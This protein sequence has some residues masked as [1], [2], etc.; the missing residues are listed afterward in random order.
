MKIAYLVAS[1][2]RR[3]GGPFVSVRRTAQ[4]LH[5]L[6]VEIKVF[7]L[8]DADTVADLPQWAPL[9]PHTFQAWVP[10]SFGFSPALSREL[11]RFGP[12]VVHVHGMWSFLTLAGRRCAS[13]NGAALVISPRGMFEP[14]AWQHRAWKKRPVWWLWERSCLRAARVIHATSLMELKGLRALGQ[15]NDIAVLPNGVDLPPLQPHDQV[16]FVRTA[17]FLSRIHP[18]KGLLNL[19]AAWALVRPAGWKCVVAGWDQDGHAKEVKRA[20]K[21]CGLEKDFEFPGPA[22]DEAKMNLLQSASLFVLPTFSEN[23]GIAVAE[24]LAGALPVITTKGAPWEELKTH[25]CGWWVD[26]GA[27]PLAA[28]FREAIALSDEQR[29][30][31]GQRG[32][33]LVAQK[34]AWPTI[35]LQMKSVYEWLLRGGEPPQCVLRPEIAAV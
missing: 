16:R 19:V 9:E 30:Q 5:D 14:W 22:Y 7:G 13:A 17:L 24:A 28:A 25:Q 2:S 15:L 4:C 23:F 35:A 29:Q 33:R 27:E 11:A 6:G 18:K 10:R 32:R 34:Y 8:R 3:A 26:I 20:V 1:V 21:A 31:M 12:D